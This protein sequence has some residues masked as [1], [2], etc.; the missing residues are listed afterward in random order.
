MDDNQRQRVLAAAHDELVRWGIDR[1]NMPAMAHRHG[2]DYQSILQHW[3][4]H[5]DALILDVLARWPNDQMAV[6]DT[7]NVRTDLYWLALSMAAYF[8][9]TPGGQL[10]GAHLV[11]DAN[12]PT[13]EIRRM[14]WQA[15]AGNARV[16]L[17]RAHARGELREGVDVLAALEL[18]FAPI[19]MRALF[20]GEPIDKEY[21]RTVA[22]LVWRAVASS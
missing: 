4:D 2:L 11:A 9:S 20:S 18:L 19:N 1:F 13:V 8:A 12:L 3:G 22:E 14:A 5:P 17:D 21:C 7:G 10:Q 15:R 16:V 6:P